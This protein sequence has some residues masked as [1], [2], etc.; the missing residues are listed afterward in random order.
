MPINTMIRFKKA[1]LHCIIHSYA[2][3]RQHALIDKAFLSVYS[4]R[5][6]Q[7][8]TKTYFTSHIKLSGKYFRGIALTESLIAGGG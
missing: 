8:K 4:K 7:S 2:L 3:K 1:H 6:A 5:S